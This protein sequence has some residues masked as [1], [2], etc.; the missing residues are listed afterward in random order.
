VGTT[1]SKGILEAFRYLLEK[2][3]DVFVIGQGVWSPWYV[4]DSMTDLEIDFGRGR[5]IDSPVSEL[6]TT[7][8]ALGASLMGYK[9]IVIHPRVDFALLAVDQMVNQAAKW[10][11]MFGGTTHAPVTFRCIVNRGGE[12][13]AQHSQSLLSWFAHIPGLRVVAPATPADARDLLV[14]S[15][16]CPDPVIYI[17]DRWLYEGEEE[18]TELIEID[19]ATVRPQVLHHGEDITLVGIGH[20][21]ALC[22]D[23]AALVQADGISATVIDLR[24]ANPLHVE[25]VVD[26]VVET[27]RL[28]VVEEDW[29]TCGI[30]GEVIARVAQEVDPSTWKARPV[31]VT[32]PDAPAP[33]SRVLEALYYPTAA[34]VAERVHTLVGR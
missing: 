27:G 1:Y 18:L 15:V 19:L 28:C 25:A 20:S 22:R 7:G 2:H 16:L 26:S 10:S 6:A 11:S 29:A 3:E 34:D 21:T 8:A 23:A 12:Q 30:A 32:L 4:G 9:P 33:T 5:V 13:G 17:D 31:R 14:A 24:V